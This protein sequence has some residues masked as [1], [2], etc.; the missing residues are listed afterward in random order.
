MFGIRTKGRTLIVVIIA[1]S[2]ASHYYYARQSNYICH[3]KNNNMEPEEMAKNVDA[4]YK[5]RSEKEK[6]KQNAKVEMGKE[7]I[8]KI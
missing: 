8:R 1:S 3:Y 7:R 2:V 5:V 4:C 6:T